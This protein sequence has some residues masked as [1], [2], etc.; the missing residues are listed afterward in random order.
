[1]AEV[2]KCSDNHNMSNKK[3]RKERILKNLKNQNR[4]KL[5]L[6]IFTV[7]L[8]LCGVVSG[9]M[10]TVSTIKKSRSEKTVRVAFYGLSEE[11][12]KVLKERIP[13]EEKITLK[14]DVLSEGNLDLGALKQK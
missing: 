8:C 10:A 7:I 13:V 2:V 14:C 1:M 12:V 6:L 4:K 5:V 11:Y 9:V 3:A